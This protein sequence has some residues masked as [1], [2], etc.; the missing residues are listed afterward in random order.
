MLDTMGRDDE[1]TC[2]CMF[3]SFC[4]IKPARILQVVSL[5]AFCILYIL[6]LFFSLLF[7]NAEIGKEK[8]RYKI[9]KMYL[10]LGLV[11]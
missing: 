5:F 3:L 9:H 1:P 8:K 10:G 4:L 6:S 11:N 2:I 7:F